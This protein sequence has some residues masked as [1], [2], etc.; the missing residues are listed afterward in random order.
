MHKFDTIVCVSFYRSQALP[1]VL[2]WLRLQQLHVKYNRQRTMR[3]RNVILIALAFFVCE[4]CSENRLEEKGFAVSSPQQV[5]KVDGLNKD[6][7]T[8]NTQP[9]RVLL[10]AMPNIRLTSVYKVN[11]NKSD[12]TTFIGSNHYLYND[13]GLPA[14]NNWHGNIM[15]GLEGVYGYNFVNISHYDIQTNKRKAFFDSPVLINT[16]YLPAF[17]S[18]TLNGQAVK[19]N[20]FLVSV[21]NE[22]TNKDG[23]INRSDLRRFYLFNSNAEMQKELVPKNYS[24]FKS[25]YDPANDFMFVFARLD[26][27]NNGQIEGNEP[28]NVFWV[29]LK[30]PTKTG[31]QY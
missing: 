9:S 11:V 8:F 25:D 16:L 10:T 27:N 17:L 13:T 5:E 31:Q 26:K 2:L 21:Y 18:D 3:K 15:P 12:G 14:G 22:D 23:F 19:R 28:G 29:D 7:L 30:D 6:S 20:Y 24:V 4:S 1:A